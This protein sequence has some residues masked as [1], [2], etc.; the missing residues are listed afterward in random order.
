MQAVGRNKTIKDH[1]TNLKARV[2]KLER[3]SERANKH[4]KDMTSQKK[5]LKDMHMLKSERRSDFYNLRNEQ[6][7]TADNNRA[8]F[9]IFRNGTAQ[10]IAKSRHDNHLYNSMSRNNGRTEQMRNE[11]A[12]RASRQKKLRENQQSFQN[13]KDMANRLQATSQFNTY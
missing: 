7:S 9:N 3:E 1:H 10:S 12:I 4:I 5:F 6:K 2:I 11:A 8:A 13:I